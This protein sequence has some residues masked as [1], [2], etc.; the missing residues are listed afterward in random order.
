MLTGYTE[1]QPK[2]IWN[3]PGTDDGDF[4][5]HSFSRTRSGFSLNQGDSLLKDAAAG[6][7]P[8]KK[9]GNR[10]CKPQH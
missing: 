2:V 8:G 5:I 6:A 9:V 3:L 1:V 4:R 7:A 10:L